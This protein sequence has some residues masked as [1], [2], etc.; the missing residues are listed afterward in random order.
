MSDHIPGLTFK[1]IPGTELIFPW[2]A[3]N[4][5]GTLRQIKFK[6]LKNENIKCDLCTIDS[7]RKLNIVTKSFAVVQDSDDIFV[8]IKVLKRAEFEFKSETFALI[9]TGYNGNNLTI[10]SEK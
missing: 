6:Q 10:V 7:E 3:V 4:T 8:V 5:N 9:G 1:F 2:G